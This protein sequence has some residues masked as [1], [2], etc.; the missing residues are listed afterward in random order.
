VVTGITKL[1]W[2]A[3]HEKKYDKGKPRLTSGEVVGLTC[4]V[5][6][7]SLVVTGLVSYLM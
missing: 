7:A 1:D 4:W 3:Q 2:S 5:V 6:I